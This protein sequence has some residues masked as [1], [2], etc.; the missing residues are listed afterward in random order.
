MLP[1]GCVHLRNMPNLIKVCRKL[2][3]DCVAA[4]VGFDAHGGFSHA[5]YDG[6][7]ICEEFK[8]IVVDAFLEDEREA[9]LKMIEKRQERILNNWK[10][11]I[12]G[13]MIREKLRLKYGNDSELKPKK[14]N[15]NKII[16]K[17][18]ANH[19]Q[20]KQ[21]DEFI[22]LDKV[23]AKLNN[24]NNEKSELIEDNNDFNELTKKEVVFNFKNKSRTNKKKKIKRKR[25]NDYENEDSNEIKYESESDSEKIRKTTRRQTRSTASKLS[26]NV[27]KNDQNLNNDVLKLSESETD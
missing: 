6:W 17:V 10:K 19:S 13:A 23:G 25:A 18:E 2:K 15:L 21:D 14:K 7:I 5:V 27:N 11:L 9:N 3:I 26:S 12:K 24:L 1:H 20:D 4:V 16:K 22:E 8:D